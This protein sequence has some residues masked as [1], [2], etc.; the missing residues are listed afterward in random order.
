MVDEMSNVRHHRGTQ[1]VGLMNLTNHNPHSKN[2]QPE[3]QDNFRG[4]CGVVAEWWSTVFVILRSCILVLSQT[5][6]SL[7]NS[8][9]KEFTHDCCGSTLPLEHRNQEQLC[10]A[11]R[12]NTSSG[13][14]IPSQET[15][16]ASWVEEMGISPS[17]LLLLSSEFVFQQHNH[18]FN[19]ELQ[20]H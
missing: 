6:L 5:H 8:C 16:I 14:P 17:L 20:I 15:C 2:R 9:G 13:S 10:P 3:M 1:T 7:R 4:Y 19:K 18:K 11:A 12:T